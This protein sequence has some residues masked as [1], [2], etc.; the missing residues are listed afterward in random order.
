MCFSRDFDA[1]GLRVK[2]FDAGCSQNEERSTYNLTR[3]QTLR[4]R[5]IRPVVSVE[6]T[7]ST[8]SDAS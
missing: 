6:E 7:L 2:R 8:R 4:K 5:S 3:R 1:G